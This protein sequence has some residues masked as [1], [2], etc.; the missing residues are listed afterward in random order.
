MLIDAGWYTDKPSYGDGADI[1]ADITKTIPAID[2]PSLIAYARERQRRH[3]PLATLDS[4]ARP[5]G[6]SISVLTRASA[7]KASGKIGEFITVARRS[8]DT[9]Y[10]GAMTNEQARTLRLP[11]K[12]LGKGKFRA[13]SHADGANAAIDPKQVMTSTKTV[14]ADESLTLQLAPSGGYAAAFQRIK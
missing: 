11:L 9:W 13:T 5:N 10:V 14:T 4:C 7:S 2:L 1:T 12:F 6:Q 8:A 3:H